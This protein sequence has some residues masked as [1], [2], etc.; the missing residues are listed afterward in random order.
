MMRFKRRPALILLLVVLVP[1]SLN[2]QEKDLS[3]S[4]P[5]D[6]LIELETSYSG[7][8]VK[9]LLD[10]V[11]LEAAEQIRAAYNEGYKQGLLDAYPD[12]AYWQSLS[13][14]IQ[15][16]AQHQA[17]APSWG[18]VIGVSSGTLIV[19]FA[20]GVAACIYWGLR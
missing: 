5:V 2:A 4:L 3:T 16:A 1:T 15:T 12:A 8:T 10:A 19:G 9:A 13:E 14:S 18:V 6:Q 7:E 20:A 17:A 11:A